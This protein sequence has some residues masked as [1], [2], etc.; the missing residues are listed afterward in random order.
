[1]VLLVE[2]GVVSLVMMSTYE[3][4]GIAAAAAYIPT[5]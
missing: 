1:M 3:R 4:T 5:Y 2:K